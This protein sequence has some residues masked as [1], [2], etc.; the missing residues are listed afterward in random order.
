[1]SVYLEGNAFIDGGQLQNVVVTN[2]SIGN[3]TIT[4]SALDMNLANITNVK[5]PML[6]QDAATKLYVDNLGISITSVTLNGTTDT[7]ISSAQ[8][9]SFRILVDNSIING[10]S[11]VFDV[12]KSEASRHAHVVRTAASPGYN[13]DITLRVS[14]PPSSGIM[15]RKTGTNFDGAYRVKIL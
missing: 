6:N 10:P 2:T 1:M 8:K 9:G 7:L 14:W 15:L 13:T 11:A 4:T 3:C 5:D 12:T